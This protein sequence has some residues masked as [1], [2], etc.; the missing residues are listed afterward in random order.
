MKCTR[1]GYDDK[2]TGDT[3]HVCGPMLHGRIEVVHDRVAEKLD[4]MAD[5]CEYWK[6]NRD[7]GRNPSAIRAAMLMMAEEL[8]IMG[9][10]AELTRPPS[11]GP[12]QRSGA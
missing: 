4:E 9:A 5:L 7:K 1:C 6:R 8:R 11:G 10:N 3:A 12:A 2:G